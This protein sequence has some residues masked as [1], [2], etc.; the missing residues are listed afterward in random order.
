MIDI[1]GSNNI[2]KLLNP[3]GCYVCFRL[4]H[5]VESILV[6][7]ALS[8]QL[9]IPISPAGTCPKIKHP[10]RVLFPKKVTTVSTKMTRTLYHGTFQISK[11]SLVI[12][13]DFKL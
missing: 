13:M 4:L 12:M 10:S 3:F 8:L 2:Q 5:M 6:P 11:I 9:V 7:N 1:L